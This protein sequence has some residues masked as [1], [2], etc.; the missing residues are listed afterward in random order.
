MAL[1]A[2]F[3][4]RKSTKLPKGEKVDVKFERKKTVVGR[5][6]GERGRRH[7]P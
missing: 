5:Q 4:G 6:Q 7:P 3:M 2:L 1:F